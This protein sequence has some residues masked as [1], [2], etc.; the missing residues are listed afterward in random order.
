MNTPRYHC[1]LCA[2]L[3]SLSSGSADAPASIGRRRFHR[4]VLAGAAATALPAAFAQQDGLREGLGKNSSFTKLVP[5]DELEAAAAKQYAQLIAQA[6]QKNA[7]APDS[8]PQVQRL[9]AIAQRMIPYAQPWNGR[10]KNWRWEVNLLGSSELNAFC[11][12]GGKIAFYSGILSKLQL[13]D[14]EVATI[15]GHEV[16]HALREHARERIGKSSATSMGLSL[17]A[18]LL[19]LGSLGDVAANL[20][21]QLLTMKFSRDDESE[22]DLVGMEL[23]ARSGYDPEAG[24]RLWQKMGEASKGAPPQWLSTHPSGGSRIADIRANLPKVQPIYA[25][26]EKPPKRYEPMAQAAGK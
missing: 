12:P 22:A 19:G 16:A 15:M 8:H 3:A 25:R 20:G 4:A 23:A 24:V 10:A 1:S 6:K 5:A 11:M 9:R 17:G 18:Q 21:T 2:A 26:A 14:D 13:D 7:L